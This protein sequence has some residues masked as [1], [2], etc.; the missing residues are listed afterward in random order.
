MVFWYSSLKRLSSLRKM[1]WKITY[2]VYFPKRIEK[3]ISLN[4]SWYLTLGKRRIKKSPF[5]FWEK[6]EGAL[7]RPKF[8]ANWPFF[9]LR[10]IHS[11]GLTNADCL[12]LSPNSESSLAMSPW[13]NYLTFLCFKCPH[14]FNGD[15]NRL[16][17]SGR[18]N[19]HLWK[20]S[21]CSHLFPI[22]L[23]VKWIIWLAL[24]N[25]L[26]AKVIVSIEHQKL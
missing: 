7:G 4:S 14:L 10:I 25:G 24:V 19:H 16:R 1:S 20:Y 13:A 22:C 12:G 18:D 26:W 15:S 8:K 17:W 21:M 3:H 6:G 9:P 5:F 2:F 11:T 23:A